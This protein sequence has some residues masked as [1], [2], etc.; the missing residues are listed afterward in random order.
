MGIT[1]CQ[2][3]SG[4]STDSNGTGFNDELCMPEETLDGDEEVRAHI[5]GVSSHF[6]QPRAETCDMNKSQ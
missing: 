3:V 1:L 5:L 6:A 2:L 4:E